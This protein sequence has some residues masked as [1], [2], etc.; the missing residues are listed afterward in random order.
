MRFPF[1]LLLLALSFVGRAQTA[2][3]FGPVTIKDILFKR[4]DRDTTANAL[5]LN[6]FGDAYFE[7][8]GFQN[9]VVQYH[10]RMRVMSKEGLDRATFTIPLRENAKDSEKMRAVKAA[11][12]N[13]EQS[14]IVKK[15]VDASQV[16]TEDAGPGYKLKKFAMPNVHVGTVIDVMYEIETPF[17]FNLWPWAFQSDIPKLK[18]EYH[19]LIPGNYIYNITLRGPY[20]LSK[21]ESSI[22][23]DCFQP[24]ARKA[25]CVAFVY[26]MED[27][28]AFKD[29]EHM[30]AKSNFLS[31]INFELSEIRYFDGRIV[32]YTNEWKDVNQELLGSPDFGLQVKRNKDLYEKEMLAMTTGMNPLEKAKAVY[33]HIADGYDWNGHY[34]KYC[35]QGVKRTYESKKGNVADINLSLVAALQGAGLRADPVILSTRANGLPIEVHPV[36][37]DFNYVIAQVR[38]DEKSYLLDATQNSHP[39]GVIPE[40]CLNGKGRRIGKDS[41]WVDLTP[42]DKKKWTIALELSLNDEGQFA[43]KASWSHY[44]YDG[45]EKRV[46]FSSMDREKYIQNIAGRWKLAGLE[47]YEQANLGNVDKPFIENMEVLWDGSGGGGADRIY[48]NPFLVDRW[49]DNPFKSPERNFPVDF[50]APLDQTIVLNLKYPANYEIVEMPKNVAFA[51]PANGGRY[52]FSISQLQNTVIVSSKLTLNKNVY[53]SNEYYSLRELFTQILNMQESMIVFVK[54]K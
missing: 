25:D 8:G 46:Q 53:S 24:G 44:G 16:Y 51:L 41:D 14:V 1:I 9:L 33:R 47:K 12:Y 27:I 7:S 37:S 52:L 50:G 13:L 29:E 2:D 18:S 6:E 30:T 15:E 5:I 20:P 48:F 26:A 23:K 19:A 45:A 49:K 43:G 54:R 21:N 40:R 35:E 28:P 17:I 38:V 3:P 22:V 36:I 34:G 32:K 10:V 31:A 4:Y 42:V 39:F 11:S